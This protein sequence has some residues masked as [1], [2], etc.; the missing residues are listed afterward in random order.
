MN[1]KGASTLSTLE[2][3][4]IKGGIRPIL[5]ECQIGCAGMS[6]GDRCYASSDC[7]CPG[8]CGSQ[9]CIAF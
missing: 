1:L 2:Q 5:I 7:N 4:E 8:R 3:K 9:G 6:N